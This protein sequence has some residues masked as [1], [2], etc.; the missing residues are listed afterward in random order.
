MSPISTAIFPLV[1]HQ[2][3][4][5][6]HARAVPWTDA[7]PV[8]GLLEFQLS[9]Y[10]HHFPNSVSNCQGFAD[11]RCCVYAVGTNTFFVDSSCTTVN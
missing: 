1:T 5:C 11:Y 6:M 9:T 4:L 3:E 8:S 2:F 7:D 10:S